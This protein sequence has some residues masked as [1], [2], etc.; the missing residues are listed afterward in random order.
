MSYV[1]NYNVGQTKLDLPYAN[2]THELPL[3]SFGDVRNTFNLSLIFQSKMTSNP[4]HIA[5]GYKLNIQKRIIISN[6]TPQ[7]YEDGDGTL[8]KLNYCYGNK[9]AFD[10]GS[11]R[12]IRLIN[13]QYVLENPDYSTEIF[14]TNG[15]IILTKDKY[16]N[17]ILNYTYSEG[18]LSS[19]I[20]KG[21]KIV[22]FEYDTYLKEINYTYPANEHVNDN[23]DNKHVTTLVYSNNHLT[24]HHYSKV[25]YHLTYASG[26][27]EV[28]SKNKDGGY[29]NDYSQKSKVI[30]DDNT[31]TFERYCGDKKIDN[32]VYNFVDYLESGEANIID[33]TNFYNVTTRVQVEKGKPTYSYEK[34][35]N[36]FV[37]HYEA[38]NYRYP[39]KVTLYNNDQAI[40]SQSLGDDLEMECITST[41]Y[42][43][44]NRFRIEGG[45]SGLMTVSGWIR[46]IISISE[47]DITIYNG[48]TAIHSK[49]VTGLKQGIWKYFSVSFYTENAESITATTSRSNDV[50]AAYDFRLSGHLD[51]DSNL[52]EYKDNLIKSF[53]VLFHK[54]SNNNETP[55]PIT[56]DVEFINGAT[57]IGRLSYPITINDLMRFKINQ[58]IGTNTGEIYYNDG[59]GAFILTGAFYIR[60]RTPEGATITASISDLDIGKMHTINS[61]KYIT[62]TH[63]Y[64]EEGNLRIKTTSMRDSCEIES[65]IYND[66]L[67]LIESMADGV[68]T[69]YVRNAT[70][71]LVESQIIK[72]VGNTTEITT[73]A[74]YDA[75]DFLVS[76]TDEFGVTTTYT[77][78]AE[79]GIITTQS[80]EGGTYVKDTFDSD[81]ST[82]QQS[83]KFARNDDARTHTFSYTGG[84]LSRL[85][86]G[87][88][89]YDFAYSKGDLASVSKNETAMET[90]TVS[91]DRK[92]YTTAYG[93][94]SV[95]E[96][97]DQY[98]RLSEI[99]NALKNTYDVDPIYAIN[100]GFTDLRVDNGNAK[101]ARSEDKITGNETK[102]AYQNGQLSKVGVFNSAGTKLSGEE[103]TYDAIGRLTTDKFTYD[104]SGGKYV[105]SVIG[106]QKTATDPL[107]DSKINDFTYTI[108]ETSDP[109]A[110]LSVKTTNTYEDPHGRLTK[111]SYVIGNKTFTKTIEYDK[112]RVKKVTDSA[113][114]ATEYQYDAMGRITKAGN[115]EYTY[116]AYGQ[117]TEE[118]SLDKTIQ[119]EYNNVGSI[120]KVIKNGA[121]TQFG[122]ND[123]AP[124]KLISYNGKAITYNSIGAVSSYDGWDYTWSKGKLSSI[125]KNLGSTSRAIAPPTFQASKTYSYTYNGRGQRTGRSYFYFLPTDSIITVYRG[126][127]TDYNRKYNYDNSGRLI[128]ETIN[129]TLYGEGESYEELIYLYDESGIIGVQYTNGSD[130]D[131]Y[132]YRR[133]IQ[134]DVVAIYNTAGTKVVEYEYDAFGNCTIKST[135][136]NTELA[137]ANPIRYRGYYYDE[138]TKL[139]Y[140]NARYYSPEW[141]RFISPDDTA[142]LDSESVN[143]LNLYCYCN[144][145]PVNYADP[146]GK[147]AITSFL[148]GL[149]IAAA[150]GAGVGVASYAA[151]QVIDYAFTG[152][153]EWS[154]GDMLNTAVGSAVGG[155]AVYLLGPNAG[156][157][158]SAFTG[159]FASNFGTMAM[160][161]IINGVDHSLCDMIIASI[162]VG[163]L[164]IVSAGIMDKIRITGLNSGRGSFSAISSQIYTKFYRGQIGRITHITFAKMV[165]VEAYGSIAGMFIDYA[166]SKTGINDMILAYN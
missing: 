6:G 62:K 8:V 22:K 16:N 100:V 80:V 24:I 71:G 92:T 108:G 161:K 39:S 9:Y 159:G 40:G 58:A 33:I 127:V 115:M 74:A 105:E 135:T 20:Y 143:G 1:K 104:N 32:V 132:Y 136:T 137:H 57:P 77:T 147:F 133:N 107:A 54:N 10:D 65:K 19:V 116:D 36:M 129:K 61:I 144:N 17:S 139:Y 94:Y 93:S 4:F 69:T 75:N 157:A 56:D 41:H 43:E 117:L 88:L 78:D 128:S 145:D 98:G 52:E 151:G 102:Y 142:Y 12:F 68:I 163:A 156:L 106:Y 38:N 122:Y 154:W 79:W 130:T 84:N 53:G 165:A 3:L 31:I 118:H 155:M 158:L 87:G 82:Q 101:L 5:N 91:E 85:A 51:S 28:Y 89:E 121:A 164:S 109:A 18:K 76:T 140:L 29:S 96:K 13:G 119:Y 138:D 67:D 64:T 124:D 152:T 113:G 73:S 103:Y 153:W 50:L 63:F 134:G 37:E 112:T 7:S 14:D 21:N 90:Y 86:S 148:I 126:E 125:K 26:V 45:L 66:K 162:V 11:R 46:P 150:I 110:A 35:E 2:Y 59:R 55:I 160:E 111:K 123:A 48:N 44:N 15:N 97:Y 49:T 42:Y 95:E 70:T 141:R 25:D 47:C 149:G 34:L 81:F 146:S 60:Y 114:G 83:R 27:L 120:T 30:T 166:Y 99:T 72:D 23:L 131:V